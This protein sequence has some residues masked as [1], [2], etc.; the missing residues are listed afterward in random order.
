M[1]QRVSTMMVDSRK[2]SNKGTLKTRG[3]S[4]KDEESMIL[5]QPTSSNLSPRN[6]GYVPLIDSRAK[7]R[8]S[9]ETVECG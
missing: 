4:S 2:L 5:R 6:S 7:T 3:N 9:F 1:I 8:E